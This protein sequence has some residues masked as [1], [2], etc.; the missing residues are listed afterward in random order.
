MK[1]YINF[2]K[3][4]DRRVQD[5]FE[6]H[7]E[8]IYCKKGCSLCCEKGD[9][10]ISEIELKYLFRGLVELDKTLK[11]KVNENIANI[12]KGE[13]CPFLIDSLCSIYSY[14]PIIC[15]VHG[16]SYICKNNIVKV[17]FC[18][19]N[20]LNYSKVYQ[21]GEFFTEPILENLNTESL[22]KDFDFGEIRNLY[23]WIKT[24]D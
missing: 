16:L 9:Y 23:D 11:I 4:L 1:E 7:S 8:F 18:A 21:K 6:E 22:L 5:Y 10:P 12:K 20:N 3:D 24:K 14:R 15:R 13:K 2:L 17:P 19:N